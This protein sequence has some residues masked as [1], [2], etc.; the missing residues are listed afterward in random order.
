MK[1]HGKSLTHRRSFLRI[2][3]LLA[4]L[5]LNAPLA[6]AQGAPPDFTPHP[7]LLDTTNGAAPAAEMPT[8]PP[9]TSA[10]SAMPETGAMPA[11]GE[12]AGTFS[13]CVAYFYGDYNYS[14]YTAYLNDPDNDQWS[15][16]NFPDLFWKSGF[17][18]EN[19]STF[20]ARPPRSKC[21][22]VQIST[23]GSTTRLI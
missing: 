16:T 3:T 1:A 15:Y 19:G 7:A 12:T 17:L 9:A 21:T 6:F 18:M 13:Y 2:C 20:V 5:T 4:A 14:K 10:T 23:S 22:T 11:V 8:D